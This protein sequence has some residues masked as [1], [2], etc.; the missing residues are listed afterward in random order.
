MN[1]GYSGYNTRWSLELTKE[2]ASNFSREGERNGDFLTIFFGANDSCLGGTS[3]QH[4]PLEEYKSN[5]G[6][7]IDDFRSG[8]DQDL[9]IVL[10][11][12]PPVH[13]EAWERFCEESNY[14]VDSKR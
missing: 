7:M 14:P 4:V 1:R 13:T 2:A 11:P 6:I 3:P 12:P 5:L 10:I 9:N 8:V